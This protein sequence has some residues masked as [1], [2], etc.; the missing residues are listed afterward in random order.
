MEKYDIIEYIQKS[1]ITQRMDC[2]AEEVIFS[3][4]TAG[5]RVK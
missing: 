1:G 5:L 4:G 2:L 3:K